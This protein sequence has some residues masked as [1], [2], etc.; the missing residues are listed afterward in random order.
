MRFLA[1]T[2]TILQLH[3]VS[4][5]YT[6]LDEPVL[7]GTRRPRIP[8][9]YLLQ[10]RYYGTM[11]IPAKATDT[12]QIPAPGTV[13]RYDADTCEGHGYHTDTCSRYGTTVRCRYLRDTLR[14]RSNGPDLVEWRAAQVGGLYTTL[15][16]N[17]SD[18]NL[19]TD[20]RCEPLRMPILRATFFT[21]WSIFASFGSSRQFLGPILTLFAAFR[22][23][24]LVK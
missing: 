9:R 19:G 5:S 23:R 22:V 12:I 24:T 2:S 17:S 21:F 8:Y 16:Y 11:Q 1:V 10:V 4:R 14:R 13:L 6:P 7:R 3:T 15:F 18:S 20:F